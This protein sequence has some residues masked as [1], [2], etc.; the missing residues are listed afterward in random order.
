MNSFRIKSIVLLCGILIVTWFLYKAGLNGG[1]IFDDYNNLNKLN[2]F[3]NEITLE[4]LQR[5]LGESSAGPLKRP[6]SVFSFLI[7]AQSWPAKP[8]SFKRT[9]LIIHLI[10]GSLL[11]LLLVTLFKYKN[12]S[13][14]KSLYIAGFSAFMWLAH[15][16]L[17]STTLYIVQ[18]MAMLPLMFMLLGFAI[19]LTARKKY[20]VSHGA[21]GHLLLFLSVYLMT[22]LAVL[23]KENGIVFIWL[24]ALFEVFIVQWYLQFKLLSKNMSLWLLKLPS[25]A[26][27]A[28]F[29]IQIPGFINGYDIREFSMTERLLTQGRAVSKY[30]YH[31]LLPGYFTDG[32]FTDGFKHST[33]LLKPISTLFSWVFVLGLL[34]IA[35]FKRK[36]WVWFS[37]VVFFFFIAQIIESTIVPLEL[38]YE[39]RVYVASVFLPVALVMMVLKL[40]ENSKVFLIIPVLISL[41]IAG[42]TYMRTDIWSNNLQYHHLTM[43]KYPESVRAITSTASLYE[44]LGLIGDAVS[45]LEEGSTKHDNLELTFNKVALYC[46][47]NRIEQSHIKEVTELLRTIPY[48]KNDQSPFVNMVRI[49]ATSQCLGDESITAI[50]TIVKA[51]EKNPNSQKVFLKSLLLYMRADLTRQ[52]GLYDHAVKLYLDSFGLSKN[53]FRLMH[54]AIISLVDDQQYEHAQQVLDYEK[55]LYEKEYK[56]KFDW[57]RYDEMISEL[58]DLINESKH[59]EKVDNHTTGKE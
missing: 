34:F 50:K 12:F 11:F 22:F 51:A 48:I 16:F 26:V 44:S 39:H 52:Q 33:G 27:V 30:I 32:V 38:Y 2:G 10:N 13:V 7:D 20:Q 25:I 1:F 6:I 29:I 15:P 49:I 36:T 40:S 46:H 47:L 42:M 57:L 4:K 3:Q 9:N 54:S 28:L 31:L 17:V 8:Y 14:N 19:Y 41:L 59:A 58:S 23:S 21:K 37:F 56:Y 24:V 53:E 5:Y 18:R 35:W 43:N 45:M 55:Y